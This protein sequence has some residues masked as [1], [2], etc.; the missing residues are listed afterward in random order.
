M[1]HGVEADFEKAREFILLGRHAEAVTLLTQVSSAVPHAAGQVHMLLAYAQAGLNRP[2]AAVASAERSVAELPGDA[3]AHFTLGAM[4][5]Q[6]RKPKPALASLDRALALDPS[7]VDAHH[8]RAQVLSDLRKHRE[9]ERAART[10]IELAPDD[11]E[12]WFSL[13]YVLH[14]RDRQGATDA[15]RQALELDPHHV[16][17]LNNLGK[18]KVDSGRA[19]EGTRDLVAALATAPH[20]KAPLT[21]LD[22]VLAGVVRRLHGI[23]FVGLWVLGVAAALSFVDELGRPAWPASVLTVVLGVLL[24]RSLRRGL[25]PI[26]AELP[27]GG[28]RHLRSWPRRDVFAATWAALIALTWLGLAVGLVA[29]LVRGTALGTLLAVALG[30]LPLTIGS[31]ASFLR[32]VVGRRRLRDQRFI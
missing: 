22:D 2:A 19:T 5:F 4:L 20:V 13:G 23:T 6:A 10:A 29:N 16:P 1:T 31:L 3:R 21:V 26:R 24:A 8:R 28:V 18:L 7:Y 17:A 12:A 14:D 11:V 30:F 32:V 15:Y 27:H 25:V 9:G